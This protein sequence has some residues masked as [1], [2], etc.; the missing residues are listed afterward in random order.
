MELTKI[1]KKISQSSSEYCMRNVQKRWIYMCIYTHTHNHNHTHK[2]TWKKHK[3]IRLNSVTFTELCFFSSVWWHPW[4]ILW[5]YEAVWSGRITSHNTVP[6]PRGLRWPRLLQYW[7]KTVRISLW[8]NQSG[9]GWFILILAALCNEMTLYFYLCFGSVFYTSGHWKSSIQRHYF[10]F[11][12][13]MNVDIWQNISPSNKN[14]SSSLCIF[15]CLGN[16]M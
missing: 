1:E 12:E 6:V 3:Y 9:E 10:Y 4:A 14:V 8:R 16:N 15:F 2:H 7:G 13:I 5:S 11:V